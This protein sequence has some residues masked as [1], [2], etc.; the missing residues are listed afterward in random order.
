MTRF[1]TIFY[2]GTLR[3]EKNH[4]ARAET[5]SEYSESITNEDIAQ[6]CPAT[7]SSQICQR[8]QNKIEIGKGVTF[9]QSNGQKTPATKAG[10]VLDASRG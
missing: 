3:N 1:S 5:A 6:C 2:A 4:G 7:F 8:L 10:A 9:Q